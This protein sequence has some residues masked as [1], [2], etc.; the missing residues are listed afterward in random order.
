M[1]SGEC[2]NHLHDQHCEQL[3]S[4]QQCTIAEEWMDRHC[5]CTCSEGPE[6]ESDTNRRTWRNGLVSYYFWDDG[7]YRGYYDDL[8]NF[9]KAL[10]NTTGK[11]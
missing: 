7:T 10:S 6:D 9:T 2:K 1:I 11:L 4:L 5:Y 3:L 8:R